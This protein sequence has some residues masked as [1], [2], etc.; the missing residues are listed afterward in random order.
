MCG[1]SSALCEGGKWKQALQVKASIKMP[2]N[3]CTTIAF[4]MS[5]T[6]IHSYKHTHIHA[7]IHI[8]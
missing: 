6:C 4:G 3:S 1:F 7:Y 5:S 8:H 2:N